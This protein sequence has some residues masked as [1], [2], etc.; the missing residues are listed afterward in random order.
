MSIVKVRGIYTINVAPDKRFCGYCSYCDCLNLYQA[1]I[2]NKK[3]KFR[4]F[5]FKS[6]L[7]KNSLG[8]KRCIKC[9][10]GEKNE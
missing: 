5:L 2:F 4:C 8:I 7:I 9:L 6:N 10:K 1:S 3:P